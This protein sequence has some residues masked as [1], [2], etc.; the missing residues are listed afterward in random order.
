LSLGR[1]RTPDHPLHDLGRGRRH[2]HLPCVGYGPLSLR[3]AYDHGVGDPLRWRPELCE[4]SRSSLLR[5]WVNGTMVLHYASATGASLPTN[6]QSSRRKH[7]QRSPRSKRSFM[8]K[9]RLIKTS[10]SGSFS[11]ARSRQRSEG[12][13]FSENPFKSVL[14]SEM[15]NTRLAARPERPSTS[16]APRRAPHRRGACVAT[17]VVGP[18]RRDLRRGAAGPTRRPLAGP[19]LVAAELAL[20]GVLPVVTQSG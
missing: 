5:C 4:G 15:V 7:S 6:E 3:D 12:G 20:H 9:A 11:S 2:R 17:S 1:H 19:M 8:P 13:V 18:L 14:I 16:R 10:I